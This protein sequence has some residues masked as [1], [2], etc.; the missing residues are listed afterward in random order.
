MGSN[1]I[2]TLVALAACESIHIT[3]KQKG[4]GFRKHTNKLTQFRYLP[5]L[6]MDF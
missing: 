2:P 1:V 5:I 3:K 6:P 4:P